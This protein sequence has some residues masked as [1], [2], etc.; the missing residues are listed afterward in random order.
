MNGLG[1]W[2]AAT[3]L[4]SCAGCDRSNR[5]C[6]NRRARKAAKSRSGRRGCSSCGNKATLAKR[7]EMATSAS[8]HLVQTAKAA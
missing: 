1:R 2:I 6:T 3:L 7:K 5:R 8:Q 4:L